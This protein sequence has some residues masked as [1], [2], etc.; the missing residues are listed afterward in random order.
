MSSRVANPKTVWV[1]WSKPKGDVFILFLTIALALFGMVAIY[2]A[3]GYVGE[4]QYGDR[5]YFVKKQAL[6]FGVGIVAMLIFTRI[7][8]QIFKGKKLRWIIFFVPIV[9]LA[10]VFVPGIGK[11]N[12]GATRWIGIGSFTIQPSELAK[13]GFVVLSSAYMSD[14][15]GRVRTFK[16]VLPVLL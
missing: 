10:L 12:Y 3:S 2:S 6:G 8:C 15:M 13:Y 7:N 4:V 11:S 9:L 5:W 14:N 1:S 16:G